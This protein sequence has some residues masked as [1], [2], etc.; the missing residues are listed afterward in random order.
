MVVG[1]AHPNYPM[2]PALKGIDNQ[3]MLLLSS[4]CMAS[5]P[6]RGPSVAGHL[7]SSGLLLRPCCQGMTEA[8][9]RPAAPGRHPCSCGCPQDR[10]RCWT[11][12]RVQLDTPTRPRWHFGDRMADLGFWEAGKAASRAVPAPEKRKRPVS[13]RLAGS[14][15]I[16]AFSTT[17]RR[18][19]AEDPSLPLCEGPVL[20]GLH[21]RLEGVG[22]D[23]GDRLKILA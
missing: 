5:D 14:C 20:A 13:G 23:R 11:G 12:H 18:I 6:E 7:I 19:D 16:G 15:M 17:R 21:H 4:Y 3:E 9:G 10:G 1:P 22:P 8:P 2:R